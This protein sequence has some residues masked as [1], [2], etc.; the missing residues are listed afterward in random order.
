MSDSGMK[1][2]M[3]VWMQRGLPVMGSGV[4]LHE[5]RVGL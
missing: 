3:S 2:A 5:L 4:S 1:Y